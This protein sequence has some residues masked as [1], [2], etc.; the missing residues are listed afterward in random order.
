MATEIEKKFLVK[1]LDF[2]SLAEG[3]YIHQG[4]LNTEKE[5]VVRIRITGDKGTLTIK[6]ITRGATRSEYEYPVPVEDAREMLNE[7][8]IRPTIEKYRYHIHYEGFLWEVDEFLGENHGLV[9][10]EIELNSEDQT[11]E[12]PDWVG[13][14]VTDDPRYFNANLITHPYSRW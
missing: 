11:F 8:C 14:E 7:L 6:G 1:N 9:V 3:I 2:K 13:E 5:R 4:F 12:M 10:A